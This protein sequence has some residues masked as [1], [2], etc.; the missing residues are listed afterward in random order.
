MKTVV[1]KLNREGT[2]FVYTAYMPGDGRAIALDAL[3]EVCVVG[4]AAY[5]V[6][7]PFVNAFQTNWAGCW[8]CFLTK[9]SADGQAVLYSTGLGGNGCDTAQAVALDDAGNAYITGVTSST[10]WPTRMAL[11]AGYHGGGPDNPWNYKGDAFVAK[12]NTTLAGDAS[13][14]Y[15]TYLGGSDSDAGLSIALD[16]A[17]NAYVAG[18]TASR[19]FPVTNVLQAAY[20]GGDCDAFVAKIDPTGSALVYCTYLG[21][22]SSDNGFSGGIAVDAHGCVYVAGDTGSTNFPT[23]PIDYSV[24]SISNNLLSFGKV[25]LSK[26]SADGSRF[27]YSCYLMGWYCG[28]LAIDPAGSAFV[29]GDTALSSVNWPFFM[30]NPIQLAFGGGSSDAA[31]VKVGPDGDAV[32]FSSYFGGSGD[33]HAYAVATDAAGNAYVTGNTSS[34]NFPTLNPVQSSYGGGQAD[35]F[36]A[37]MAPDADSTPPRLIVA[38]N[39]EVPTVIELTFS[40]PISEASA[41]NISNY[42]LDLGATVQGAALGRNSRSV[43]LTTSALAEGVDYTLTVSGVQD[44]VLPTPNIILP[45][46]QMLVIRTRGHVLLNQFVDLPGWDLTVPT[47]NL[48]FP[49]LPDWSSQAT[50]LE[51]SPGA[52]PFCGLQFVGFVTPPV[53]G[54]YEFC[55]ASDSPSALFLSTDNTP[56]NNQLL[57]WV[58]GWA[59]FRQ[60]DNETNQRSAPIH[61]EAGKRYAVEALMKRGHWTATGFLSVAW[62]KPGEP[63]VANG[64]PPISSTFLSE[65]PF[66]GPV[67]FTVQPESEVVNE[68]QAAA[69]SGQFAGTPP[70]SC[71]WFK[72]GVAIPGATTARH[73][74][75]SSSPSEAGVLDLVVSNLLGAVSSSNALLTVIADTNPPVVV[76]AEGSLDRRRITIHFS[77]QINATDAT[78]LANYA[79]N[80]SVSVQGAQL[81]P[82]G[83]TVILT[84]SEQGEGMPYVLTLGGIRDLSVAQ[85]TVASDTTVSFFAWEGEEFVGP[86]PSWAD[87]KRDYEAVGDGVADDTAAL[88]RALDELGTPGHSRVLFLPAGTYRITRGLVLKY[89]DSIGIEGEDPATTIIKWDGP[90]DGIMLWSNGATCHRVGRITF[91]GSG[92]ALSAVDHKWDGTNQPFATSGS[93]YTDMV[94]MDVAYGIRAGVSANDAEVTVLRCHFLRCTQ[95]GLVVQSYNALDWFIWHC[96]FDQCQVGVS[97]DPGAGN[98]HVYGSVFRNSVESDITIGNTSYF[99]IRGNFSVGSKA[100]FTA[101]SFTMNPSFLTI[102]NNII[103]DPVDTAC[104][105][106]SDMGPLLLLDNTIVSQAG[107]TNGPVVAV[108]EN[109][110]AIGNTFTM[111]NTLSAGGRYTAFDNQVLPRD[112]VSWQAIET[113]SPLT[114]RHR[115]II[116]VPVG[117][118]ASQIQQ[119][120]DQADQ[121]RGSRPVVHLPVG[122]YNIDHTLEVPAGCDVQLVGDG[123][124]WNATVLVWSGPGN[125]LVLRLAGPTRATL[126]EFTINGSHA[127]TSI[128]V[129]N[130]DQPGSRVFVDQADI[131][132]T[133]QRGFLADRLDHTEV[134]LHSFY[135]GGAARAVQVIGGPGLARGAPAEGRV[136]IFGGA[137][138]GIGPGGICS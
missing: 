40:K 28:G 110:V 58:R 68:H 53:T 22:E 97:D 48:N 56:A 41:T 13:L 130:C 45:G 21:G 50:S 7:F 65:T 135:I 89:K 9:L 69:F 59:N 63:Q 115:T 62:R 114:N 76:S 64:D 122:Q 54:D 3:G 35:I 92:K 83:Q 74:I 121:L 55:I 20:G 16:K 100:F 111:T 46:T 10:N 105:R 4:D 43:V 108:M 128:V 37:K 118:T 6:G 136:D 39:P 79:I 81:L 32:A 36:V 66:G 44:R 99:S 137:C 95:R 25:C 91:D 94:F 27:V 18:Q 119:A 15:S 49:T 104:I 47:N 124:F 78:N 51:W 101:D 5:D 2:G 116:E 42:A 129:E 17:G 19:D 71:Q 73:F 109:L 127:A 125:G 90:Q 96:Q 60:W 14:V 8:D 107:A 126:R 29:V 113:P 80:G 120:I 31:I 34:T 123:F 23:T 70:F 77:E 117:A 52:P 93:E 98:F 85:N 84:T 106:L 30:V 67:Q 103:V 12:I 11:Q 57:A 102:Q 138:G 88:Q 86:F 112:L 134:N 38:R 24:T 87:V 33:E 61:L 75:P 26:L 1:A 72:D 82:D 133:T 131:T 132:P